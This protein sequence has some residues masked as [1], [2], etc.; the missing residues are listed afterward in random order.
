V[1]G[2]GDIT[3][4]SCEGNKR[5]LVGPGGVVYLM[6]SPPPATKRSGAIGREIESLQGVGW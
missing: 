5:D 1:A 2:R 4:P 6:E 3:R